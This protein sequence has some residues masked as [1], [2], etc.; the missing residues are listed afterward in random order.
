MDDKIRVRA[1]NVRFGDAYLV[2]VPDRDPE[3]G[4]TTQRHILI[5]VGNAASKE[6]GDDS[7]F[8]PVVE[9]ILEQ[10][11]GKPLDLY[12]M[13]HEHMDHVQGLPYAAKYC[14]SSDELKQKLNTQYAWLTASADP[15]YYDNHPD[16]KKQK[17]LLLTAYE[18]IRTHLLEL[19]DDT[20]K[21]FTRLLASNNP[22]ST[23][24]CVDYLRD[25]ASPSH[26]CYVSRGFKTTGIHPFKEARFEILAPEEDTSHYYRSLLPMMLTS[27][28]PAGSSTEPQRPCP[29]QG[30]DAG[31]FYDL[32]DQ[33]ANGFCDNLLA[34]DKAANNTSV[35]FSLEW[36]GRRLLFTGDAE[37]TSWK[38]MQEKGVL[39]KVDFMKVSHHLSR[40]GTPDED[41]LGALLPKSRSRTARRWAAVSTWEDMYSGIPHEETEKRLCEHCTLKSTLDDTSELFFD[42]EIP[43][44]PA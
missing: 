26:T 4:D 9:D 1:Y 22:R 44:A 30:V 20:M 10:L 3:T 13:T 34:I 31:A 38:T 41:I 2:T 11:D 16:A 19:P 7:V 33:R 8:K 27:T 15:S 17:D 29:P 28:G 37:L 32:V 6:G 24:S 23:G 25:L 21:L 5:D 12:V 36:R 42:I 43:A 18:K 35:V 40:N 39:R 14:Y